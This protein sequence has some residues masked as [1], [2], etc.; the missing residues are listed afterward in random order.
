M[1][2]SAFV[3]VALSTSRIKPLA[4]L[5]G[6]LD[7]RQREILDTITRERAQSAFE[8]LLLG[9]AIAIPFGLHRAW[10]TAAVAVLV[11]Q[12]VYYGL[13]PK[14]TWLLMHLRGKKQVDAWLETYK[15]FKSRGILTALSGAVGYVVVATLLGGMRQRMH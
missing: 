5:R 6:L 15:V 13:V 8:G 7:E 3:G 12:S 10:C 2:A 14:S 4:H 1:A 11:T 9:L